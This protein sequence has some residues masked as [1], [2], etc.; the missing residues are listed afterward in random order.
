[1]KPAF[2]L[3]AA[4]SLAAC[5]TI[6]DQPPPM[7]SDGFA[8]LGQPTRVG[9]LV[10]TPEAVIEDSRCPI[11]VR[12]IWAGRLVISAVVKHNGG[13]EQFRGRLTLG[14]PLVRGR[15]RLTLVS[16]EPSK[17]AR[18]SPPPPAMLFEFEAR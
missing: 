11:D 10:V 17:T 4:L 6:P 16:A 1:M 9:T 15:E 7:R 8:A 13:S 18:A 12:C 2:I 14:E 5:A 3:A